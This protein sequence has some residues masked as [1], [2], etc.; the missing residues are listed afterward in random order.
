MRPHGFESAT[1]VGMAER[2]LGSVDGEGFATALLG[3]L[4]EL[5]AVDRGLLYVVRRDAPPWILFDQSASHAARLREPQVVRAGGSLVGSYHRA[6]LNGAPGGFYADA[7]D[8]GNA[9]GWGG[10]PHVAFLAPVSDDACLVLVLL[11]AANGPSFSPVELGRYRGVQRA[12]CSALRL[13]WR[14]HAAARGVSSPNSD[15]RELQERVEAALDCFGSQLLTRRE[16][17][18]IRLLLR[19]SSTKAAAA[20]LGIATATA[21]LHRKRAYAKFGVR[22]QAQLFYHFICS[23]SAGGRADGQR[24]PDQESWPRVASAGP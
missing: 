5:V 11:R 23:L 13:H 4:G 17:E 2:L 22:S 15:A 7:N 14:S 6:F 21:A 3:G 16:C 12:V 24:L 10:V 9:R 20:R 1:W 18:V 8:S 19:G